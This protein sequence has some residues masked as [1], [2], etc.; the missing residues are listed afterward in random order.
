L[1]KVL[2]PNKNKI[3]QGYSSSHKGYDH[4]GRGDLNYYSSLYG[5]VSIAK[6]SE[7]KNWR[8]TGKLTTKD[9]GNYL[10]I[11]GLLNGKVVTQLGAHFEVGS[12]LPKGT[13]VK[14]GQVVARVGNT[15]N[16]TGRHSHT[17]YRDA[18]NK[19][20]PVT[21][22]D[23][24]E[25]KEKMET[26]T[27]EEITEAAYFAI[28]GEYPQPDELVA[29]LQK[30]ENT[31]DLITDLLKGDGRSKPR[32]L[33]IWEVEDRASPDTEYEVTF[34]TV[35]EILRPLD[36]RMGD[37]TEK[38]IATLRDAIPELA[39]LRKKQL[40]RVVYK[41]QDKDYQAIARFI[42]LILIFEK[43]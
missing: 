15:G 33:E 26:Q 14:A 31:V 43:G 4:S 8:N 19:N 1:I 27:K 10:K 3:T 25:D 36:I 40:P 35:R 7:T 39:E 23:T 41:Y 34:D 28:T 12:V 22:V 13:E 17:E 30:K 37:D 24:I 32:W 11:Q 42:N 5:K 6:N 18:N 2:K 16:S 20:F 29:R 9:Y 38:V 21:F